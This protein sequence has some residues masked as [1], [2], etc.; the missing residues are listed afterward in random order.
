MLIIDSLLQNWAGIEFGGSSGISA[1]ENI[2]RFKFGGSVR[3]RHDIYAYNKYWR[4]FNL[5]AN[6]QICF[7]AKRLLNIAVPDTIS[8]GP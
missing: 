1:S 5:G 7:P 3:Y 6:R 8:R 4:I 2:G